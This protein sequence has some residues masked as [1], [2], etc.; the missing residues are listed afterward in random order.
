M[1][2][3]AH[4]KLTQEQFLTKAHARHGA[5]TYDYS[6]SVYVSGTKKVR[7]VCPAH[8]LFEQSAQ[9]HLAGKGCRD[10][11]Q[12]RRGDNRRNTLARFIE[13]AEAKHGVGTYNYSQVVY[14]NSKVPVCI[15]CPQHGS[16]MQIPNGHCD[17]GN[18][19]PQC[20]IDKLGPQF[21]Y[22]GF[23]RDAELKHADKFS[24]TGF[25]HN[26]RRTMIQVV[27]PHHGAFLQ[28]PY[29]HLS[30]A[31]GC[32]K[33]SGLSRLTTAEFITRAQAVHGLLYD[34]SQ[35]KYTTSR[36]PV[37]I[38]CLRHGVF[39]QSPSAHVS[40]SQG[41]PACAKL[42]RWADKVDGRVGILYVVRLSRNDEVFFKVG[43]TAR[44][45][46]ARF[47]DVPY[48]Y[49]LLASYQSANTQAVADWETSIHAT[50]RKLRYE[51]RT[52]FSGASECFAEVEPILASLPVGS[53][54]Y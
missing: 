15:I 37:L 51:P 25:M 35:T 8:G 48:D 12:A 19:C 43:I 4:N 27:C 50:F 41:C 34:Y 21:D 5:G 44:S 1:I 17:A 33:C 29:T 11:Y 39:Y 13:K 26:G 16:F 24:Y 3:Q 14:V 42:P 49:H 47:R 30:S 54:F 18:G 45:L 40:Q 46:K 6:Q 31:V 20:G 10:C 22:S 28:T 23:L 7:I 38:T 2:R 32:R 36:Q 52:H 53:K 9:D